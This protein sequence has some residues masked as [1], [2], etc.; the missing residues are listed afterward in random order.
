MI[1]I[2]LPT[3]NERENILNLIEHIESVI[4]R[5]GLKS[6]LVVVDDNSPDGTADAVKKVN[7]K[8]RNIRV[9]IRK[10]KLGIGSAHMFGYKKSRGDIVIAMD[11]DLSH[12]PESIPT[13]LKKLDEGYDVVVGS[14]HIKGS[15]Y[16][17][18]KFETK[19]KYLISKFGNILIT[20]ISRVP[21]HDFTNGY[22]AIRK[23]VIDGIETES[24]SNS[25]LMEFLI[26]AHRKGFKV[27]EI[28]V[29]FID[30]KLGKSKTKVG[31]EI[32]RVFMDLLKYSK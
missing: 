27:T 31:I 20:V 4:K 6:E 13:M 29:S 16:E 9:L 24:T 3:Y 14:R 8:F 1:S 26:K 32:F 17:K 7:K 11:T 18:K 25:F 10:E 30:R 23:K 22:R 12:D 19:K 21:I 28:P 15:Y 5:N 2:V